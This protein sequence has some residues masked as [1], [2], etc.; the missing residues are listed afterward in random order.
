MF[1]KRK[2]GK[3]SFISGVLFVPEMKNNLLSLGQFL[4]KGFVMKMKDNVLKVYDNKKRLVLK[5]PMSKN[6]TFKVGINGM[7]HECLATTV[8]K[9]KW[10]WHYKFGHL[11]FRIHTSYI[12]IIWCT[13]CHTFKCQVKYVRNAWNTSI[14][15]TPSSKIFQPDQGISLK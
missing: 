13:G 12:G 3:Q 7:G 10:L 9:S 4:E 8:S 11:N 5:D 6:T 15:E 1:I 2:D 14:L